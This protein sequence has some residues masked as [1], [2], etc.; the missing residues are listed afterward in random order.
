MYKNKIDDINNF[1]MELIKEQEFYSNNKKHKYSLA[2]KNHLHKIDSEDKK[3]FR[4]EEEIIN[5]KKEELNNMIYQ[6]LIN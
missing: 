1:A 2:E 4:E 6:L 5:K 3:Q